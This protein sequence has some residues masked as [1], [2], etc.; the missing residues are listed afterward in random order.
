MIG[1]WDHH[2]NTYANH[3]ALCTQ[4][5]HVKHKKPL[6]TAPFAG[7]SESFEVDSWVVK[8]NGQSRDILFKKRHS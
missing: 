4:S 2:F 7:L 8:V 3:L 6:Y 1:K 5:K